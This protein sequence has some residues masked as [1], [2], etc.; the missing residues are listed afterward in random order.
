MNSNLVLKGLA[1]DCGGL[2][3]YAVMGTSRRLLSECEGPATSTGR[4]VPS[5]AIGLRVRQ[6]I[7]YLVHKP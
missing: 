1:T 6:C 3:G 7:S 2:V 5:H 4:S